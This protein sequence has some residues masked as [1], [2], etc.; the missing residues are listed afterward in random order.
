MKSLEGCIQ[1]L[2]GQNGM[3]LLQAT[4]NSGARVL[5]ILLGTPIL[6]GRD[7]TARVDLTLPV[8]TLLSSSPSL[9]IWPPCE[10]HSVGLEAGT[11]SGQLVLGWPPEFW[12]KPDC[13]LPSLPIA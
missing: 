13:D 9:N 4:R 8:Q 10:S 1:C 2:K 12:L 5:S 7:L 11:L 3:S 6:T